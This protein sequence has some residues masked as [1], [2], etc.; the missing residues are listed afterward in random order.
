MWATITT[1]PDPKESTMEGSHCSQ[2]SQ[3][4]II[5]KKWEGDSDGRE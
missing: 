1:F 2:V 5:L 3:E 4:L